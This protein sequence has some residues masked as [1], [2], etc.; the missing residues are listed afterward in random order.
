MQ[1]RVRA[2]GQISPCQGGHLGIVA[3]LAVRMDRVAALMPA[4]VTVEGRADVVEL[5]KD[6]DEFIVKILV[7]KAWQTERHHIE[8]LSVADKIA[9]HLVGNASPSPRET[10]IAEAQRC[11]PGLQTV[12][13]PAAPF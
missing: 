5:V 7:E 10:A 1:G 9:L 12:T 13:P 2:A 11:H 3:T 8:H 6:S 4:Q